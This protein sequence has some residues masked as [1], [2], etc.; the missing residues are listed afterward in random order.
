MSEGLTQGG[1]GCAGPCLGRASV[2]PLS[3]SR[4]Y[5]TCAEYTQFYGGKKA[6]KA[7]RAS[8][9]S[10]GR[11]GRALS[12]GQRT[13]PGYRSGMARAGPGEVPALRRGR[14]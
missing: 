2:T 13:E 12:P 14:A 10:P 11:R 4:R 1:P 9:G 3:L 6:G 8:L 7:G 5:I